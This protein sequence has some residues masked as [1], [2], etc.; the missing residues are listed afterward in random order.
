MHTGI[1]VDP[2]YQAHDTGAGHP[3]RPE[4]LGVLLPP[5]AERSD[6]VRVAPR[7]ATP[8]EIALV[9]DAGLYEA[10]ARSAT[11]AHSAFDADTPVCA[12]SFEIARLATG[13][14]LALLDIRLGRGGEAAKVVA[15]RVALKVTDEAIQMYGGQGIS[16]DTP[17]ARQWTHL[18]TL[19]LADGPDAV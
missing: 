8:E 19:R 13:G 5:L 14:L 18:R 12:A 17:L 15:P 3:E 6:L 11:R 9:H 16:Q 1:V 4:R 2:R 10:V 7:L